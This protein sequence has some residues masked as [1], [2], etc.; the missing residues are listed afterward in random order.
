MRCH[1]APFG[2]PVTKPCASDEATHSPR[3]RAAQFT[4]GGNV[5]ETVLAREGGKCL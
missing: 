3:V 2:V 5:A 4:L 1:H